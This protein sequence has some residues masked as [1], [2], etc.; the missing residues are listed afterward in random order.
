[1]NLEKE[2][3]AF[4]R[5]VAKQFAE[6]WVKKGHDFLR[7]FATA[8][9][10][11]ASAFNALI[12]SAGYVGEFALWD[13]VRE[14]LTY[15]QRLLIGAF[16][17]SS[18]T[19]FIGWHIKGQWVLTQ[20]QFKYGRVIEAIGRG[21]LDTLQAVLAEIRDDGA[22]TRAFLQRILPVVWGAAVVFAALAAVIMV[23]ACFDRIA[24]GP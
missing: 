3:S 23:I 1:M 17:T 9:F 22:R 8:A 2:P 11:K 7:E 21:D 16:L 24:A 14:D 19:I 18:L 10:D 6:A 4:E 5:E 13:R 15:P 12:M 20:Q